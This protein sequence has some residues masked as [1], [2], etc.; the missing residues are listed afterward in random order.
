MLGET[1]TIVDEKRGQM[2][3]RNDRDVL[4]RLPELGDHPRHQALD[5][6]RDTEDHAALERLDGVLGDHRAR[7]D[8]LDLAELGAAAPE[9]LEGDLDAR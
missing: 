1:R 7:P 6:R 2:A 3:R 8:E 9:R 5:L 4:D